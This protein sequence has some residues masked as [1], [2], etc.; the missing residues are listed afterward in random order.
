MAFISNTVKF[1]PNKTQMKFFDLTIEMCRKMYNTLLYYNN[2]IYHAFSKEKDTNPNFNKAKFNSSYKI[3]KIS[4]F[5]KDNDDYQRVDSLALCNEY[6]NMK[7]GMQLFYDGHSKKPRFKS[8]YNNKPSYTTNQV[9]NN[10]RFE[11]KKLRL[12]KIG[13]LKARGIREFPKCFKIKKVT[14]FKDTCGYYFASVVYEYPDNLV[15]DKKEKIWKKEIH[16]ENVQKNNDNESVDNNNNN[17]NS[18]KNLHIV[19]L[20]FKIDNIFVSSDNFIPKFPNKY[21]YFIE[22]ISVLQKK[23]NKKKR[24][25]NNY[26]KLLDILRKLHRKIVN[27]RKNLHHTISSN[28]SVNYDIAIIED[29]SMKQISKDLQNGKNTYNTAFN[30]F[31]KKLSYKFNGLVIKIIKWFPSSKKCSI[32]GNTK[33][34]LK[35]SQRIY[36][37]AFCNNIMDRDLNAAINIRSEG[38]KIIMNMK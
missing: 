1:Y 9:N 23:L 11:G 21:F 35:L 2:S 17:N 38:I 26:Y 25:S 30:S 24:N 14:V 22:Q 13:F 16:T 18:Y 33:K 20:D 32:C 10:I 19:G 36:R 6:Y 7:R 34:H 28:L 37:C 12:P 4:G 29:L 5:K 27:I 3:P 15:F 8:K 31:I